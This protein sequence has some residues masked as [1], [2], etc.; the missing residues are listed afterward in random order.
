MPQFDP[1]LAR[2]PVVIDEAGAPELQAF[3]ESPLVRRFTHD[4]ISLIYLVDV[5]S[6][7]GQAFMEYGLPGFTPHRAR[8]LHRRR[9]DWGLRGVRLRAYDWA[10]ESEVIFVL[11]HEMAHHEAGLEEQHSARWRAACVKLVREAGELGL[12]PPERVE[13]A[14][15]I[16]HGN[17]ASRF[18]GWPERAAARERAQ[19]HARREAV[20]QMCAAG[21]EVGAQVRFRYRGT[22]YRGEVVRINPKTVTVGEPGKGEGLLRVPYERILGVIRRE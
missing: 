6:Y 20:A 17:A 14:V 11:C 12:L 3:L 2:G 18:R 13:Q 19:A 21:L 15:A 10:E 1:K 4:R 8:P 16:V 7:A 9:K 5:R 22:V